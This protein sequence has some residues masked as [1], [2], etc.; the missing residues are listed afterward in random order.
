MKRN[1]MNRFW[2]IAGLAA[3]GTAAVGGV[4]YAI[5]R[6]S[7][8]GAANTQVV[9]LQ[10]GVVSYNANP[11]SGGTLTINVPPNCTVVSMDYDGTGTWG[12]GVM[13]GSKSVSVGL[14][15]KSGT[16]FVSYQ[17]AGIAVPLFANVYVGGAS[18]T[19]PTATSGAATNTVAFS[20]ATAQASDT[21]HGVGGA[22][23]TITLVLPGSYSFSSIV[24][25][26]KPVSFPSGSSS[27]NVTTTN[28]TG[29]IQVGWSDVLGA[30]HGNT[31]SYG[32]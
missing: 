4:A 20:V 8:G 16:V 30:Q 29:I 26:G 9:N 25:D 17:L 24:I 15:G 22:G 23:S 32:P 6:S 31:L 14:N 13:P 10:M 11:V 27:V 18:A 19:Q 5:S 3:A 12:T 1:P 28:A 7:G 2:W 21:I